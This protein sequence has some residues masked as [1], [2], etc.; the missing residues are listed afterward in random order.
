MLFSTPIVK[1]QVKLDPR[2]A[3][4]ANISTEDLATIA[5]ERRGLRD[6]ETMRYLN[7]MLKDANGKFFAVRIYNGSGERLWLNRDSYTNDSAIWKYPPDLM[8][9]PG[10]WSVVVSE[11]THTSDGALWGSLALGYRGDVSRVTA[12][13]AIVGAGTYL[14]MTSPDRP[15]VHGAVLSLAHENRVAAIRRGYVG[16]NAVV[17]CLYSTL[18]QF[19]HLAP[20]F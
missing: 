13:W 9:D 8:I 5:L 18:Q 14:G 1:E 19:P 3:G 6:L 7:S 11:G 2:F 20:K 17:D 15:G 4:E 12:T 10:Q 16:K